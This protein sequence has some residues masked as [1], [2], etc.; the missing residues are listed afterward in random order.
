VFGGP[1]VVT[2]EIDNE[3]EYLYYRLNITD[4]GG[5]KECVEITEWEIMVYQQSP[6]ILSDNEIAL[7]YEASY[8][9][10]EPE[11]AVGIHSYFM[12][13]DELN[14]RRVVKV[15]S[16]EIDISDTTALDIL[17]VYRKL[18]LAIMWV[19]SSNVLQIK[20][21]SK[22][23]ADFDPET[24][25]ELETENIEWLEKE[26]YDYR[27]ITIG[28]DSFIK[29]ERV[30]VY[31]KLKIAE[32]FS[33]YEEKF[34]IKYRTDTFL[35]ILSPV[36]FLDEGGSRRYGVITGYNITNTENDIPAIE[37]SILAFSIVHLL[38]IEEVADMSEVI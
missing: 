10:I 5:G 17:N 9:E 37:Y 36:T 15:P 12:L 1:G 11:Y 8:P 21:L 28:D 24:A 26:I 6:Q 33:S 16:A 3:D 2:Y 23:F 27:N 7:T 20:A 14:L 22:I 13:D 32:L 4:R 31:Y 25:T 18:K 19:D 35:D 34:T 38:P 30:R 29:T